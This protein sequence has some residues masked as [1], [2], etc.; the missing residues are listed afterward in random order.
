MKAEA[1]NLLT[2]LNQK[3]KISNEIRAEIKGKIQAPARLVR[4]FR[5]DFQ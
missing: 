1:V 5:T 3:Q 4:D 2:Q